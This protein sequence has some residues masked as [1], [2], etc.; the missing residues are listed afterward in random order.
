M[1]V[2]ELRALMALLGVQGVNRLAR[3]VLT[4]E[5]RRRFGSPSHMEVDDKNINLW[6]TE[7]LERMSEIIKARRHED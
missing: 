5:E 6:R 1:S 2:S 4:D 7:Q 3:H